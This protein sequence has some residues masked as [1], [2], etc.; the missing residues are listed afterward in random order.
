MR[1]AG[2]LAIALGAVA[3]LSAPALAQRP[4]GFGMGMGGGG[5]MLMSNKSVQQELKLDASQT[6]KMNKYAEETMAK[7]REQFQGLQDLPQEKRREKM[8]EM[9]KTANE[10]NQKAIKEILK[11]EQ[12]TRFN[13][14]ELQSRRFAAFADPAVREKMR[15]T[16]EQASQIRSLSESFQSEAQEIRQNTQGDFAEMRKQMDALNKAKMD[17]VTA[18]L[19]A[20]QKKTWK[21]MTG[22]PFEVK[23]EPPRRPGGGN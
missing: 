19:T 5:A 6:E 16:E 15:F 13:Q 9:M 23:F 12:V 1:M 2:R 3:A 20:D 8:Q 4:G 21:E 17:K 18:L 22:E 10:E 14:I 11:P 7:R